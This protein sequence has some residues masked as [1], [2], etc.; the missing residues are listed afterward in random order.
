VRHLPRIRLTIN[1]ILRSVALN[2]VTGTGGLRGVPARA[3]PWAWPL[4]AP[5]HGSAGE[6]SIPAFGLDDD[7][8]D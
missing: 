8:R 6:E 4:G 5:Q 3:P 7:G 1:F 2:H